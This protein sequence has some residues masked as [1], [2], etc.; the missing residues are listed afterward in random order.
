[1][2]STVTAVALMISTITWAQST[3]KE[4][5]VA[6]S[7][8][9]RQEVIEVTDGV[10]VAVGFGLANSILIEGDNGV[11]IVDT[12]ESSKSAKLVRA[13]FD[14]IT[15]KPVVAIIY[16]HNHYDHVYGAKEFVTDG[17]TPKVYAHDSLDHLVMTRQDV[18]GRAIYPRSIRQ[19]GVTLPPFARPN[20]GIGPQLV[21]G[22]EGIGNYLVP[23]DVFEDTME[24]EAAG[25]K[26]ELVHAPGETDDQLYVWLPEKKVLMPGDNFYKAFPNLYAVR[27][28]PYR[29]VR[30]WFDSLDKMIAEGPEFLVPSHT[31]PVVGKENIAET[32]GNYRDGIKH[33]YDE[34][35]AGMNAGKTE[36]ELAMTIA[37]P[38]HLKDLPYLHEYYGTVPWSVRSI[39]VGHLGWFDGNATNLFRLAPTEEAKRMV[40]LAGGEEAMLAKAKAAYES[41]DHQWA[42]QL[43]DHLLAL[44]PT[45][46]EI[47]TLKGEA[48]VALAD[49]MISANGRNYYMTSGMQ[50]GAKPTKP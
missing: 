12:M 1:M 49:T 13:E 34:T 3:N 21:F 14:K 44:D 24:F 27:G 6:H 28:T 40:E 22:G 36:D 32:L 11:I 2:R 10:H 17:T 48:L 30:G 25:V 50:H 23:T 29:D 16:T 46:K 31:R 5:L 8:E 33:V 37:L 18:I 26:I 39:F 9:F 43:A 38:D 7:D 15:D 4:L 45:N 35:V 47:K 42:A 20:A 41:G 19:F